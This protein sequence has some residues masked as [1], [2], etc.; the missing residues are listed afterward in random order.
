MEFISEES[1]PVLGDWTSRINGDSSKKGLAEGRRDVTAEPSP[2]NNTQYQ[3]CFSPRRF[4]MKRV[5]R[6]GVLSLHSQVYTLESFNRIP[7]SSA[8]TQIC[9]TSAPSSGYP[10]TS[11]VNPTIVLLQHNRGKSRM[12]LGRFFFFQFNRVRVC[13]FVWPVRQLLAVIC[14]RLA[15]SCPVLC[16]HMHVIAHWPV[17][18]CLVFISLSL[19]TEQQKHLSHSEGMRIVV[20]IN[21]RAQ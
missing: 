19:A 1:G 13:T 10:C 4:L 7:P 2:V 9:I 6:H 8:D 12:H 5:E 21:V 20:Q 14:D 17:L 18:V 16:M 15:L 11:T 3:V